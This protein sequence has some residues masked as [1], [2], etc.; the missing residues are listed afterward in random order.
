[1]MPS[2]CCSSQNIELGEKI[3]QIAIE[4][5]SARLNRKAGRPQEGHWAALPGNWPTAS[6]RTCRA[7]SCSWWKVIRRGG[8]AKQAR[9]KDFQAIMPLRGKIHLG[10]FTPTACWPRKKCTTWRSRSAATGKD[11]ISGLRYGRSSSWPTRT[12][13]ACTSQ[14]CL[15]RCSSGTSLRWSMPATCSWP[16]RHCS[17]STWAEQVFMPLDEEEK[18]SM[19]DKIEREKI[20]GAINVT[21]FRAWAR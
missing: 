1:M 4:R 20:K 16:C 21:R 11:D 18:R 12:P 7:P 8:G 14:H 9:D 3:A 6:A 13:T 2:A 5:A 15:P 19:L 10:G 17:A